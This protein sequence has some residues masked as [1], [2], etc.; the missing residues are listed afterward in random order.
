MR[1]CK[2]STISSKSLCFPKEK[3]E[4]QRRELLSKVPF[5]C[6][7][8]CLELLLCF[9]KTALQGKGIEKV[10]LESGPE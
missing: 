3:S 4:C 10:G 9:N 2:A 6:Q 5:Q 7:L 8:L 1:I